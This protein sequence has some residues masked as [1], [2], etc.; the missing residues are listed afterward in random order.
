MRKHDYIAVVTGGGSG[1][2]QALAWILAQNNYCVYIVGRHKDKLQTTCAKY[3]ELIFPIE[4]DVG[5]ST[6]INH[7]ADQLKAAGPISFLVHN[8]AIETPI[9][10][11]V[12]VRQEE[13]RYTQSVNVEGPFFLTQ[14]LIQQKQLA[15][16]ARILFVSSMVDSFAITGASAY[17][18]SKA[19]LYMVYLTMKLELAGSGLHFG[20]ATPGI[21]DTN[22][23]DRLR[24]Y[25]HSDYFDASVYQ[26][27]KN[28]GSLTS[29]AQS[30]QFM[31]NLLLNTNDAEFSKQR[32]D[33]S[34]E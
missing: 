10:G 24:H 14:K 18:V 28:E 32:W 11:V 21:V 27:F 16:N 1:I 12:E 20:Y 34:V 22:M 5:N 13:W 6:G 31:A 15:P 9:A 4:A 33:Y 7:I 3:P 29:A 2:G 26:N 17:C 25:T 19:G 8:A 23:Q 30:A